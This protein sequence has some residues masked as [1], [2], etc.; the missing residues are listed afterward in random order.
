MAAEI[1]VVFSPVGTVSSTVTCLKSLIGQIPSFTGKVVSAQLRN[2]RLTIRLEDSEGGCSNYK[3][4]QSGDRFSLSLKDLSA[5]ALAKALNDFANRLCSEQYRKG[6]IL[7]VKSLRLNGFEFI[8]ELT[9]SN[10]QVKSLGVQKEQV[11]QPES[12]MASNNRLL[13]IDAN[14]LINAC[15]YA[16][17]QG[18]REE[19][20]M[21]SSKGVYT[22]AIKALIE[23]FISI[24]RIYAPTHVAIACDDK[25]ESLMRRTEIYAEYKKNREVEEKPRPLIEQIPL[26]Y[27][28]FEAMNLPV[29]KVDQMEADDVIGHFARR[30][31]IEDRGDVIILSNDKD[32]F[33]LLDGIVIQV[34]S[35]N[36][37][38]TRES[39]I[40]RYEGLT[41]EQ[42]ADFKALCGEV[43]DN[44]P[45]IPGVGEKTAIK[46]LKT[47]GSLEGVLSNVDK[48][49]GKLKEKV[50]HH[51]EIARMSKRLAMLYTDL[52]TLKNVDF[53]SLS[54]KRI[55]K[56]GMRGFLEELEINISRRGAA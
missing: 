14:N 56:N 15:Y 6:V 52:P 31:V 44:I 19:E 32:L 17:A 7:D 2:L 11:L 12:L 43:G 38:V 45:G 47:F 30:F 3:V 55:D 25:R 40:L 18:K 20:L 9:K 34:L 26:A 5:D 8:V 28:L 29:F 1:S 49:K 54:M 42:F 46:L 21:K 48:L 22:N 53:D 37:E 13:L 41:P 27:Q 16:T 10:F 50:E 23:R 4:E 36:T 33:Q 51:A 39:F 35:G 24:V